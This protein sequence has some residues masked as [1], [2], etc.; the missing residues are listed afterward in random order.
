[1]NGKS[2]REP[3]VGYPVNDSQRAGHSRHWQT[4]ILTLANHAV[5]AIGA[6]DGG[7]L[8]SSIVVCLVIRDRDGGGGGG[9]C[10]GS[11]GNSEDGSNNGEELHNGN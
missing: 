10:K 11:G 8:T 1:M 7:H 3:K 9:R 5:G 4:W 2:F 6:C